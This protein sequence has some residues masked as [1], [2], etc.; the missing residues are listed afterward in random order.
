MDSRLR[1]FLKL[2]RDVIKT[3]GAENIQTE[4]KFALLVRYKMLLKLYQVVDIFL[5]AK[6]YYGD[7]L[8]VVLEY[9]RI[10]YSGKG[11]GK[12]VLFHSNSQVLIEKK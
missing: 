6:T 9:Y 2:I 8:E 10:H 1:V 7:V 11:D 12:N 4:S 5:T 3:N